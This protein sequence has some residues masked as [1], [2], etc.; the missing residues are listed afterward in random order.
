MQTTSYELQQGFLSQRDQVYVWTLGE[1]FPSLEEAEEAAEQ[2][3]GKWRVVSHTIELE[4][5]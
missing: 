2:L 5:E 1:E 3:N 4:G